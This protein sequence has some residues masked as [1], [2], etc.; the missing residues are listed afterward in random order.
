MQAVPATDTASTAYH[1]AAA[2]GNVAV[3]ELLFGHGA[4]PRLRF[5][6]HMG[7][8]IKM[9]REDPGGIVLL[10]AAVV[11]FLPGGDVSGVPC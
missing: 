10:G 3:A 9:Y 5:D 8:S 6:L 11:C 7:P 2:A 1:T 4:E